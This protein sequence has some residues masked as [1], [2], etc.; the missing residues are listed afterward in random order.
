MV[1]V[2][3]RRGSMHETKRGSGSEV[4][5]EGE[6]TRQEDELGLRRARDEG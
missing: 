2:R 3:V 1:V 6:K 4:A 5:G